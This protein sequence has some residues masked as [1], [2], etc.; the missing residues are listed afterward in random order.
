MPMNLKNI[1]GGSVT[2]ISDRS[3]VFKDLRS[4][5]APIKDIV[6]GSSSR[7]KRFKEDK[8]RHPATTPASMEKAP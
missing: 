4:G 1:F 6:Q 5:L 8:S 7:D 3:G 2:G